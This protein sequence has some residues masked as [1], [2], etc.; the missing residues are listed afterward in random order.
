MTNLPLA[1]RCKSCGHVFWVKSPTHQP[2][3]PGP[4]FLPKIVSLVA[5]AV[6]G[7]GVWILIQPADASRLPASVLSASPTASPSGSPSISPSASPPPS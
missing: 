7:F 5:A 2:H 3:V 4:F 6:L 1:Q